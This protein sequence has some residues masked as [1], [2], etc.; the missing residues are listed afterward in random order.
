MRTSSAPNTCVPRIF[1]GSRSEGI[2]IHAFKPSRAD[3]A[4][5]EFAR[6]PVDEHATVSNPKLRAFASA[7]ATTRSLKLKVGRQ[8]ASFLTKSR[9]DPIFSPSRGAETS[10]VN[11]TGR[12]GWYPAGSG[13]NSRERHM[14]GA[15]GANTAG[16]K[17]GPGGY[18]A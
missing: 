3:C 9:R 10:G 8:T 12:E 16:E 17:S 11:P 7:T 5:T 2:K 15:G 18:G 14:F 4:A 1:A 13:S 6:L